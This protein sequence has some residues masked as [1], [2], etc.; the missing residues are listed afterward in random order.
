M[1]GCQTILFSFSGEIGPFSFGLMNMYRITCRTITMQQNALSY[2]IVQCI[3]S[4]AKRRRL[5]C[6]GQGAS[7]LVTFSGPVRVI[8]AR[9]QLDRRIANK[10]QTTATT[11]PRKYE[12]KKT[13]KENNDVRHSFVLQNFC[14]RFIL[15]ASLRI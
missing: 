10:Q 12:G 9:R 5:C 3:H 8:T 13:E 15:T 6:L 1:V 2:G 14:P 11:Q 7:Q 4:F